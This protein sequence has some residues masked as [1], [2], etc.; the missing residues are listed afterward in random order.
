MDSRP[1]TWNKLPDWRDEK[2][3]R[4]GESIRP[5]LGQD[6][7]V[8]LSVDL[9]FAVLMAYAGLVDWKKLYH[10]DRNYLHM[11]DLT[12]PSAAHRLSELSFLLALQTSTNSSRLNT[13][14]GILP[15]CH[16][17]EV[18]RLFQWWIDDNSNK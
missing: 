13:N 9:S 1:G 3:G 14:P 8:M 7:A 2:A 10:I 17:I 6:A 12:H 11:K 16:T 15:E 4:K 18:H 5:A